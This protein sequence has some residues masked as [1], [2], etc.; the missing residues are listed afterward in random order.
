MFDEAISDAASGGL[1]L[2]PMIARDLGASEEE[3]RA[4]SFGASGP[5]GREAALRLGVNPA[6][7][8]GAPSNSP[9]R[10]AQR[11]ARHLPPPGER[12]RAGVLDLGRPQ[13]GLMPVEG[14]VSS[15][16]GW[17]THP[18]TG[19]RRFHEGVDIAAPEGTEIRAVQSGVVRFAGR[20]GGYGN[21]VELE[22]PDGSVSRYAHASRIHVRRGDRVEVGESVADVG[23]TGHATGPHLHFQVERDGKAVDPNAYLSDLRVAHK[24]P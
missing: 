18:I 21:V 24:G 15:P 13:P 6:E 17:R 22:H 1:G 20:R 3:V 10:A 14:V 23:Q 12:I 16:F 2:A 9:V 5:S 8:P 7:G 19:D 11:Y 4:M